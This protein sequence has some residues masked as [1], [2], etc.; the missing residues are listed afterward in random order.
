MG[1]I[2]IKQ[3]LQDQQEVASK[4]ED[5]AVVAVKSSAF[6]G[7]YAI[8]EVISALRETPCVHF[9]TDGEWSMH[10]LLTSLL[11]I[12]GPAELFISTYA[13][14]ETS[15]RTLAQLKLEDRMVTRINCVIDNRVDTRS[16]GSL[17][18]LRGIADRLTLRACHAKATVII[19]CNATITVVGSANYTE[20]KRMEIGLID[21]TEAVADFHRNWITKL[22]DENE[23]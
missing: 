14:S 19:G 4:S 1:L 18:L 6:S 11:M 10:H 5:F 20:N 2:N 23:H 12:S 7:K 15:C 16:A 9:Y 17:Q 3:I 22:L 21:C 13:L 8:A